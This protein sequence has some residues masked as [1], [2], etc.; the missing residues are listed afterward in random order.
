MPQV[1]VME[2]H[3]RF[4]LQ[5]VAS[6]VTCR[7]E[8][9]RRLADPGY[10]ER[11]GFRPVNVTP[12]LVTKKIAK[13]TDKQILEERQRYLVDFTDIPLA[14]KKERVKELVAIYKELGEIKA[15]NVLMARAKIL[16]TI[17]AEIGED[18][19]KL[20]DAI[21]ESG[22]SNSLHIHYGDAE[23]QRKSSASILGNIAERRRFTVS[24]N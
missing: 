16:E 14:H 5:Q 24:D 15:K 11:Y 8:I 22:D 6:F 21:K 7:A 20:A 23:F 9:A 3:R 2:A 18:I 19:E 4:I 1:K 13:F 12:Q 10:A 17:K